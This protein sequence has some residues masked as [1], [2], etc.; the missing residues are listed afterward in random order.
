MPPKA[1]STLFAPNWGYIKLTRLPEKKVQLRHVMTATAGYQT[2]ARVVFKQT[3]IA[4]VRA[5]VPLI[6]AHCP[7]HAIVY[8]PTP[9]D[10]VGNLQTGLVSY[11]DRDHS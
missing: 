8:V 3:L 1:H 9:E 11:G 6:F 5:V 7:V 4:V 10:A 2:F